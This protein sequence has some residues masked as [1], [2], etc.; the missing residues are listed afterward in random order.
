MIEGNINMLKSAVEDM[1]GLILQGVLNWRRASS[2]V[3]KV[4]AVIEALQ[5]EQDK[6]EAAYNAAIEDAKKQRAKAKA[7]AAER[8]EEIVGGETINIDLT[9]GKQ[10]TIIE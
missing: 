5:K 2:A 8:G 9:T 10:E 4:S 1:N 7:E 6:K 3:S